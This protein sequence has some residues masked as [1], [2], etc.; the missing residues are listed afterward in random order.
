M[1]TSLK[2]DNY[3][4]EWFLLHEYVLV[5]SL[6]DVKVLFQSGVFEYV[7]FYGGVSHFTRGVVLGDLL[8]ISAKRICVRP[9]FFFGGLR[10]KVRGTFGNFNVPPCGFCQVWLN[11]Y[12]S[13]KI[14]TQQ[15]TLTTM[16][17]SGIIMH[18]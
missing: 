18:I 17:G 5:D 8:H 16:G 9:H 10:T 7:L 12:L 4:S 13:L 15:P 11:A 6:D 3:V 1:R 14:N 2:F